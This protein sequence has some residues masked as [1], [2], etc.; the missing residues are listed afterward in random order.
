MF[1]YITTLVTLL[2]ILAFL[3]KM[4]ESFSDAPLLVLKTERSPLNIVITNHQDTDVSKI[5]KV[6]HVSKVSSCKNC[7]LTV[8]DFFTVVRSP[9]LNKLVAVM[10]SEKTMVFIKQQNYVKDET[11]S[12]VFKANKPIG[13][14]SDD[15]K[16]L[17]T[18][19]G[20]SMGVN[21]PNLVKLEG[22]VFVA[23][24]MEAY[25]IFFF[26]EIEHKAI[27]FK[28][29]IIPYV[30]DMGEYDINILK[31]YLPY[32]L[33]RNKDFKK[34]VPKFL[35]RYTIK[36]CIAI[37]NVLTGDALFDEE[38]HAR[39][40]AEIHKALDDGPLMNYYASFTSNIK[41]IDTSVETFANAVISADK[42]ESTTNVDGFYDSR[43]NTLTIYNNKINEIPLKVDDVVSLNNQIRDEENG[44]YQ[45]TKVDERF[46]VL[47]KVPVNK[48]QEV[49][50]TDVYYE[51]KSFVEGTFDPSSKFFS[52][53]SDKLEGTSLV[54]MQKIKMTQQVEPEQN[55]LYEVV[56]ITGDTSIL[57]L[58][59]PPP[60]PSNE[61]KF[62][63]VGD[64]SKNTKVACE[65]NPKNVWDRPCDRNDE[66]PFYQK[67][68]YYRNYRGGCIDG[69]C[70]MPLG[71]KLRGFRYVENTGD[72][73]CY[74]CPITNINCCTTQA[75]P[76]YAFSLDSMDRMKDLKTNWY[77]SV[78]LAKSLSS[79]LS[80]SSF[81][82]R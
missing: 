37:Q 32:C 36:T 65:A 47:T 45:V 29:D 69:K 25:A 73:L 63:C 8:K 17:L 35:D 22:T 55:G 64:V 44:R 19:I 46:S 51:A 43:L 20:A 4:H 59:P 15:H 30:L 26:E 40:V 48:T 13:Y 42:I 12:D 1:L 31:L 9:L 57:R 34:H 79:S 38:K 50:K 78:P 27:T 24:F 33:T 77:Q 67:N 81:S 49:K 10:P 52:I 75:A 72:A 76:D 2:F 58:L 70:E 66:C 60:L 18:Y 16:F 62:I 41:Y 21:K 3:V 71:A 39:I 82:P 53:P 56:K 11:I 14:T 6:D 54:L 80:P 23:H 74:G 7:Y 5:M 61:D 68:V 28:D